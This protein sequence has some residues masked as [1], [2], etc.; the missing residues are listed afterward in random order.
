VVV[1]SGLMESVGKEFLSEGQTVI[2]VGISW[3]ETKNKI[4][5]DV[6]FEEAEPIV[7]AITPVPGGVGGVTTSIVVKHVIEAA[8]RQ[9]N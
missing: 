9:I 2:D 4:C 6:L 1:A 7:D 8:T 3:N 5:G